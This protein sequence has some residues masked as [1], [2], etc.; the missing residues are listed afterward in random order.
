[1]DNNGELNLIIRK[2]TTSD[3][4]KEIAELIYKTDDY[5]YPYW[6][7]SLE[8][9]LVEFPMLLV[10]EKFFF[11]INNL[12]IAIDRNNNKI[13]GLVCIVDKSKD[14]DYDYN[15]LRNY[16]ERYRFTIDNYIMGL[17]D[18][19]KKSDFAYISNVCVHQDYRGKKIGN[20]IVSYVVEVYAKK[21]FDEIVLDVIADNE[22]A[23]RLYQKLGFEQFTEIF[24]G[25]NGT[26]SD[27]PNVFSMKKNLNE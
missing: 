4:L 3:N 14:F 25:F 22:G 6:F 23:V 7:G 19:V 2:A 20:K 17:I 24:A 10:E 8:Q 18:E 9:C 12:Y 16:N 26:K 15:E 1:M 13:V 11:N 27:K 21:C 5:I